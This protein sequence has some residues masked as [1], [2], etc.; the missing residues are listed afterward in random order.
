MLAAVQHNKYSILLSGVRDVP[1]VLRHIPDTA[2]LHDK[3]AEEIV[4][5]Q[6]RSLGLSGF[7]STSSK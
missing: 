5:D 7:I 1:A 2:V 3:R 6:L 4:L